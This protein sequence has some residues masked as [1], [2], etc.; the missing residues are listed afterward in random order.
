MKA[1]LVKNRVQQL[2]VRTVKR[3]IRLQTSSQKNQIRRPTLMSDGT[4]CG[5]GRYL[6][7]SAKRKRDR[8]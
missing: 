2:P 3:P 4:A 1:G 8:Q 5:G 7:I 6:G